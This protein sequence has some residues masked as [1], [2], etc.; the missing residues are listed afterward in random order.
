VKNYKFVNVNCVSLPSTKN[1]Y[2]VLRSPNF[3]I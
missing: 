3:R 2:F 1:K